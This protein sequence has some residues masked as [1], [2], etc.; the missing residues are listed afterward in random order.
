MVADLDFRSYIKI[1]QWSNCTSAKRRRLQSAKTLH[2]ISTIAV[3]AKRYNA[4]Y[5]CTNKQYN[6]R[7]KSSWNSLQ[8]V[9]RKSQYHVSTQY[10][11]NPG[12]QHAKI[13]GSTRLASQVV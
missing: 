6:R 11:S 10:G 12:L 9:P 13:G 5:Y 3:I 4:T 7:T 8:N 1:P 2:K